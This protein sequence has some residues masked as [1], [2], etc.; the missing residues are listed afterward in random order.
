[1][2]QAIVCICIVIGTS[3]EQSSIGLVDYYLVWVNAF[4]QFEKFVNLKV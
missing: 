1:M 2:E 3:K 4:L